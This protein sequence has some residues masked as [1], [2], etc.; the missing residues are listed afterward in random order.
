MHHI[1]FGEVAEWKMHQPPKLGFTGSNPVL[2]TKKQNKICM[3]KLEITLKIVK[4]VSEVI[5]NLCVFIISSFWVFLSSLAV[6][7]VLLEIG[8]IILQNPYSGIII[9]SMLMWAIIIGYIVTKTFNK[10]LKENDND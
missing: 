9:S 6:L 2:V 10:F 7:S 8:G 1:T 3:S 4:C 5:L